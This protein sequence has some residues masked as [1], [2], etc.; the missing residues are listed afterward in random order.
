M[1]PELIG[2]RAI[3]FRA[4]DGRQMLKVDSIQFMLTGEVCNIKTETSEISYIMNEQVNSIMQYTGLKDKN[5]VEIYEGDI[6]KCFLDSF[7]AKI[8]NTEF[9]L[10]V[11]RFGQH[12]VGYDSDYAATSSPAGFYPK[13][14]KDSG[15]IQGETRGL[16]DCEVI[17]NV[18]ENPELFE[19]KHLL[20]E[21]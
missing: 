16:G 10:A 6:V 2:S 20:D 12:S 11:I 15:S 4:W 9:E 7:Y 3:K 1:K 5:G 21:Q 17:G 19:H 13:S 18:F 14:I 8:Y